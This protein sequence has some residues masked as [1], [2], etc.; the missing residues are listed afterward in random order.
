MLLEI[1]GNFQKFSDPPKLP[2]VTLQIDLP[3]FVANFGS[4]LQTRPDLPAAR[5]P[6]FARGQQT[7]LAEIPKPPRNHGEMLSE[8]ATLT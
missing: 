3:R 8:I 7:D 5:T 4:S 1:E 6:T 2:R